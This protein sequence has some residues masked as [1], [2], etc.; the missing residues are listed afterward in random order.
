MGSRSSSHP[1]GSP[2]SLMIRIELQ[3]KEGL[4]QQIYD[5]VRR[6]ILDGTLA[7]GTRLP[8]S[9]ALA[10]DLSVSRTT[11]L[12]AYEQLLA[13]GYLAARRG[14]GTYVADEVPDALPQR[15]ST[16]MSRT[17]H[18]L[19]SRRGAA[20]ASLPRPARRIAGPAR[21]FR[22]GVPALDLF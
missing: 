11:T 7:P 10:E 12:L 13:E 5:A 2:D 1:A 17:K 22:L 18:P 8:S 16:R 9:R 14:T 4:Q 3:V 19:L 15:V 6:A 21:A 20:L